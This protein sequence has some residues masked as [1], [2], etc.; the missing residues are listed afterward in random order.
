MAV[1]F[2]L[3]AA[4]LIVAPNTTIPPHV[5]QGN[6]KYN[7]PQ[8]GIDNSLLIGRI[9]RIHSAQAVAASSALGAIYPSG[10]IADH[11][12]KIVRALITNA[13]APTGTGAEVMLF[14]IQKN[15]NTIF[16]PVVVG[17]P[18]IDAAFASPAGIF[19]ITHLITAASLAAGVVVGDVFTM[20]RG[21]SGGIGAASMTYTDISLDWG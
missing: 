15:G 9:C 11:P 21:Y 3:T 5:F 18:K 8:E 10:A 16:D 14:D 17:L 20:T 6:F 13:V 4:Q 12:G 1:Y 7:D 19:D 2:P